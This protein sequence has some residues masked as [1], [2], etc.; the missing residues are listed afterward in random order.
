MSKGFIIAIDGPA[1]S[2]KGTVTS[3]LTE[4]L[5]AYNLY[6]GAVFRVIALY[7]IIH[8]IGLNNRNIIIR[9]LP[10]INIDLKD[11][12]TY[13]DTKD[14]TERIKEEDTARG[15]SKVAAIPQVQ[16]KM[17]QISREIGNRRLN[18]GKIVVT[19]GR[20]T[21]SAIFP[22]ADFKLFLTASPEVRAQRRIAQ[23]KEQGASFDYEEI[24]REIKERDQRDSTRSS[25][26]LPQN[27]Q[28][29][30]YFV[31]DNSDIGTEK[32]VNI[33]INKLKEKGLI[34]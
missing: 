31:L 10:K 6:T 11:G 22:N 14:V 29:L 24:L 32:T 26:P 8:K 27:P 2:G 1:G 30:G 34:S 28:E 20:N 7:C 12:K 18:E 17:I 21:G 4:K 3:I 15:S 25:Y 23:L 5:N 9:S 33:I 19:E 13:L 16:E